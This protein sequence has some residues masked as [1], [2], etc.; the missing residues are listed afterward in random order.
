VIGEKL[1]KAR[2]VA[3]LLGVG[4]GTVLDHFES[5]EL[6]GFR[7]Y[8]RKG[9]P[10]RFRLSDIEDTLE[11]WRVGTVPGNVNGAAPPKRPAP[12]TGGDISHA[13]RILRPAD[14]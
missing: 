6:P 1:L 11:A 13:L 2:D 7:L 10:V 3:D 9:G 14:E 8:G 4:M 5:G 12:G